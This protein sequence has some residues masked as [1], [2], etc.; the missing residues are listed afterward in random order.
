MRETHRTPDGRAATPT[1][2]LLDDRFQDRGCWVERPAQ[3]Q[4]WFVQRG[5]SLLEHDAYGFGVEK[6]GW[7]DRDHG[8]STLAEVLMVI[9]SARAG[10]TTCG[11]APR[12]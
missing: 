9:E 12:P 3:L 5:D 8:A 11:I 4:H 2:L 7:Y 6:Q 10:T 1:P